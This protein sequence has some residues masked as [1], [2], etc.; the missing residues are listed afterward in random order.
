M[1][2]AD[3]KHAQQERKEMAVEHS[4]PYLSTKDPFVFVPKSAALLAKVRDLRQNSSQIC[5]R[6]CDLIRLKGQ[7][8][9]LV[10]TAGWSVRMADR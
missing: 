4:R 10:V 8:V 3:L 9:R 6:L 1:G 7:R 2:I 5:E